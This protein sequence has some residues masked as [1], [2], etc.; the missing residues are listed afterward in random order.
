MAENENSSPLKRLKGVLIFAQVFAIV[1]SVVL[2]ALTVHW[3]NIRERKLEPW[4]PDIEVPI[5]SL[6]YKNTDVFP[7]SFK[8]LNKTHNETAYVGSPK[9]VFTALSH[10]AV[11]RNFDADSKPEQFKIPTP[12]KCRN[13]D[14]RPWIKMTNPKPLKNDKDNSSKLEWE[15]QETNGNKLQHVNGD[16]IVNQDGYFFVTSQMVT[17][18]IPQTNDIDKPLRIHIYIQTNGSDVPRC[19]LENAR[20]KCESVGGSNLIS[21]SV[22]AVFKLNIH[23]RLFMTISHK[24]EFNLKEDAASN[25]LSVHAT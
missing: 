2:V 19:V 12:P 21:S 23:D 3:K 6:L 9:D 17:E 4:Q 16:I 22:G 20:S 25:Y 7:E 10:L 15:G 24:D 13:E 18:C 8:G 14:E 5:S 1:Q 11:A